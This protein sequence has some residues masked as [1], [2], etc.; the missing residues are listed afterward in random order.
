MSEF[1]KPPMGL[2]PRRIWE[3]QTER[4][5]VNEISDAI[6]RYLN[7]GMKINPEWIEEINELLE[8][9]EREDIKNKIDFEKRLG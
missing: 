1:N 4:A 6:I 8:K 3:M 7:A 9:V 2:T 5:R